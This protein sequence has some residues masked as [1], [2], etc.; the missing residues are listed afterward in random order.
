MSRKPN[1]VELEQVASAFEKERRYFQSNQAEAEKLAGTRDVVLA[2]WTVV[3][4]ALLNL[5]GTMT[6]E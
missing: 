2:A 5:D 3:S 1:G 6:K 4:N